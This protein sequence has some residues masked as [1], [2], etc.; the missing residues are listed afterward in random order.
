MKRTTNGFRNLILLAMF[1]S[2]LTTCQQMPVQS[3]RKAPQPERELN[4]PAYLEDALAWD[5]TENRWIFFSWRGTLGTDG[6]K[7]YI[8]VHDAPGEV[9]ENFNSTDV[10]AAL[11]YGSEQWRN[12]IRE[13]GIDCQMML[14]FASEGEELFTENPR[15]DVIFDEVMAAGTARGNVLVTVDTAARKFL[16]VRMRIATTHLKNGVMTTM[17]R[18]D[19]FI[20]FTH[21]FGHACGIYC[22]DNCEGHSPNPND[23]MYT[24]SR[25]ATLSDGDK[26]TIL[27]I[28]SSDAFYKP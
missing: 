20:T 16:H 13:G 10:K 15:I 28:M 21:E 4:T 12:A 25:Y 19:Y 14:R 3:P 24:P 23:V 22:F 2:W 27:R 8:N 26:Q 6:C 5:S 9:P 7:L 11:R 18:E 17:C 1:G